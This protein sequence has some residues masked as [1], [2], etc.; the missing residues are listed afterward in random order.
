M[1]LDIQPIESQSAPLDVQP[2]E[3][4][5]LDIQPVEQKQKLDIQPAGDGKKL[6][7]QSVEKSGPLQWFGELADSLKQMPKRGYDV[8]VNQQKQGKALVN[9]SLA[10]ASKDKYGNVE[11]DDPLT[12]I[13]RPV[14]AVGGALQYLA[15]PA[16][17]FLASGGMDEDLASNIAQLPTMMVLPEGQAAKLSKPLSAVEHAVASNSYLATAK[18]E[19]GMALAPM[20]QGTSE[21]MAAAKSFA[22]RERGA[23]WQGQF[24][25]TQLQKFKPEEREAMWRAMDEES[26]A[27]KIG[28]KL[29][30]GKGI[31]S[32]TP[33]QLKTVNTI[34]EYGKKVW[35]EA[36][37]AGLV[38]GDGLEY[39]TPRMLAK[40]AED[41]TVERVSKAEGEGASEGINLR[42]TTPQLKKRKYATSEETE[43]AGKT[44]FGEGTQLARDIRTLPLAI[45]RLERAV[46][47]R[48]FVN[49][50][51]ELSKETGQE[52]VSDGAKEGFFTIDHPA[53]KTFRPRFMKDASGKVVPVLDQNG[54]VV[55]DKVPIYISKSL[56]GPVRAVLISK[57][58]KIYSALMSAKSEAMSMIM[59]SPLIHNLVEYSRAMPLMPGKVITFKAYR[60]GYAFKQ[61]AEDMQ[62]AISNGMAPIG[63]FGSVRDVTDIMAEPSMKAG[64]G[65]LSKLA[66]KITG[67]FVSPESSQALMSGID[68]AADFWHNTLLWDRVGDLQAG[69]YK[70]V[71][72]DMTK[73]LMAKGLSEEDARRSAGVVA[74]HLANRFA[75]TLP[76]EAMSEGARRMTN[77]LLF[78]RTFT[79]GNLGVMKD[80][81]KGLPKESQALLEKQVGQLATKYANNATK[82]AAVGAFI[83]DIALTEITRSMMQDA[84]AKM[85]GEK[86]NSQVE[87]GYIDRFNKLINASKEDPMLAV[88]PLQWAQHMSSTYDNEPGKQDRILAWYGDDGTAFYLRNP[89]GKIGDEF[90]GWTQNPMQMVKNKLGTIPRPILQGISNDEYLG[91]FD[92]PKKVYDPDDPL[93]KTVGNLALNFAVNQIP[94]SSVQASMDLYSGDSKEKSAAVQQ[95]LGS[96]TGFTSSHGFPGGPA[97]GRYVKDKSEHE[98]AVDKVMPDIR[99]LFEAGKDDEAVAAMRAAKM[100]NKE[101]HQQRYFNA[102]RGK[103]LSAKEKANEKQWDIQ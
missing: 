75:G 29:E 4:Q 20:S 82:R 85:R 47:G 77:I 87:Q 13:M 9:D 34:N 40:V 90:I 57:P 8:I 81:I 12:A 95:I 79:L 52:L 102:M 67:T 69:I 101:I 48:Q 30:P 56:E 6:D 37:K 103:G 93:Y 50:I 86:D 2:T 7:L 39:Y 35:Q 65:P 92:K 21:G 53:L 22:N 45:Q 27:A 73:D 71:E 94:M 64:A 32:L 97:V 10:P 25:D 98:K 62:R 18:N 3:S 16:T 11:S 78:S 44:A 54:E 31:S 49:S 28:K 55:F 38:E 99:K 100:T 19:L 63:K 33:E 84:F 42:T 60:D 58:G 74:A 80:M 51:R 68:K 96:V 24:F 17:G 72:Q 41:G 14:K 15:S 46:A 83:V 26:L 91:A 43:A 36:A 5:K 59:Y 89:I 76:R 1:A 61:S 66:G 23:M 88:N 70:N